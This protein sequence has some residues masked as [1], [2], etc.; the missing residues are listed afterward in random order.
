M[1]LFVLLVQVAA[2]SGGEGSPG[3][4]AGGFPQYS[5][6]G[7]GSKWPVPVLGF[8]SM[9][10]YEIRTK[11]GEMF[12]NSFDKHRQHSDFTCS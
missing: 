4:Q 5:K 8:I 11:S 9:Q 6:G 7:W 3:G 2:L 10:L 12:L 1:H